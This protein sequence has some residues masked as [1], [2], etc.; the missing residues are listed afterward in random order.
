MTEDRR[1]RLIWG[2]LLL[3]GALGA[4]SLRNNPALGIMPA[5]IGIIEC[6]IFACVLTA[7]RL[8]DWRMAV[9]ISA[10]VPVY[11]W[12]QRFLDGFM[13]PVDILVNLTMLLFM[14]RVCGRMTSRLMN[15]LLLVVPAFVVMLLGSAVA[16]WVVKGDSFIRGLIVAWNT[17]LYS[18]LSILG[19]AVL[20]TPLIE[21]KKTK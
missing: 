11:L 4:A 15:I 18:A 12:A 1:N 9:L 5:A 7:A 19:A 21:G 6:L 17:D 16:L 10:A 13:V 20:C 8:S 3:I 2:V 14:C